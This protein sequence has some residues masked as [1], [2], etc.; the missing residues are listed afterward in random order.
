VAAAEETGLPDRCFDVISASMC[1]GYFDSKRTEV[2][3]PRLLRAAGLFPVSTI[4]WVRDED[5]IAGQTDKLIAKH[6]PQAGR[7]GRGQGAEILPAWSR[8]RFCSRTYHEF[9]ADLPFTRVSWRGRI[10]AYRWIGAALTAEQ[11]EAFDREHQALLER[12]ASGKF[13]IPHR[14]RIQI[15]QPKRS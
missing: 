6:N 14:I 1:W 7:L 8:H 11:T 15:F 2:V 12:I 13:G 5:S 9:K 3:V 4:I 10:R